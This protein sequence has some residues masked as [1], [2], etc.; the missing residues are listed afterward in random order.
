MTLHAFA[1]Q[2]RFIPL[3]SGTLGRAFMAAVLLALA[4]GVR[5]DINPW[6]ASEIYDP[7]KWDSAG[8]QTA[9]PW[10]HPPTWTPD[11]E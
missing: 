4:C 1:A 10:L 2:T 7:K 6:I 8:P 11:Q 5:A 9:S 3:A